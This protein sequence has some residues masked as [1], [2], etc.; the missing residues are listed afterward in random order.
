MHLSS[1]CASKFAPEGQLRLQ[2]AP[3]QPKREMVP[4]MFLCQCQ[5]RWPKVQSIVVASGHQS[6]KEDPIFSKGGAV[7]VPTVCAL[8]FAC[9]LEKAHATRQSA[10]NPGDLTSNHLA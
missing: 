1:I 9:Q 4:M 8:I 2:L 6:P 3:F 5:R 10:A 7:A